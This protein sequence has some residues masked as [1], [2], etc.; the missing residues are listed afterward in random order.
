MKQRETD[1]RRWSW[2]ILDR[3]LEMVL[4]RKVELLNLHIGRSHFYSVKLVNDVVDAALFEFPSHHGFLSQFVEVNLKGHL[5][6][7][8]RRFFDAKMDSSAE[9]I[10]PGIWLAALYAE[11][12]KFLQVVNSEVTDSAELPEIHRLRNV[13]DRATEACPDS[14]IFWRFYMKLEALR[15][16][17]DRIKQVFYR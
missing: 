17:P 8:L 13:L 2:K 1:V 14:P 10:N 16:Q 15:G 11:F 5:M 7:K 4:E 3:Q 9:E 12:S 6:V